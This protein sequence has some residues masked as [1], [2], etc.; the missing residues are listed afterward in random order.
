ML[1]LA[2]FFYPG[3]ELDY[4]VSGTDAISRVPIL[5]F[6]GHMPNDMYPFFTFW[7]HTKHL[8]HPFPHFWELPFSKRNQRLSQSFF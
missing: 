7:V 2:V 3:N 1:F 6:F 8:M 4:T 5:R